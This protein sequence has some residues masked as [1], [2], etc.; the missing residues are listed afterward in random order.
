MN[1]PVRAASFSELSRAI[2]RINDPDPISLKAQPIIQAL[3]GE[4]RIPR[5]RV[6]ESTE[7]VLIR[8]TVP[9]RTEVS[10]PALAQRTEPAAGL[11]CDVASEVVIFRTGCQIRRRSHPTIIPAAAVRLVVSSMRMKPPVCRLR[12]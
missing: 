10:V 2:E 11:L 5:P 4:N 12:E 6:R 1:G 8:E 3:F 9:Q 7:N